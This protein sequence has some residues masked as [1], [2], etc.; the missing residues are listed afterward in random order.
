MSDSKTQYTTN[1]NRV[2]KAAEFSK[3][4]SKKLKKKQNRDT[5]YKNGWQSVNI[6]DEKHKYDHGA[7]H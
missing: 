1:V 7:T 2:K 3:A 6:N 4:I 5:K